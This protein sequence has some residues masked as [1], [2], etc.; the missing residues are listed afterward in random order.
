MEIKKILLFLLT[1]YCTNICALQITIVNNTKEKINFYHLHILQQSKD[2]DKTFELYG[3]LINTEDH[4]IHTIKLKEE[5]ICFFTLKVKFTNKIFVKNKILSGFVEQMRSQNKLSNIDNVII[6]MQ[7]TPAFGVY[8]TLDYVPRIK[9]S[10]V[11]SKLKEMI[12]SYRK[13][14][15]PELPNGSLPA[16]SSHKEIIS[17]W[18]EIKS[19]DLCGF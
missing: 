18:R 4:Q 13:G 16:L 8:A 19:L 11:L 5:D 7:D 10:N 14:T 3:G 17:R 15:N 6:T 1:Y 2:I 12:F 9:E